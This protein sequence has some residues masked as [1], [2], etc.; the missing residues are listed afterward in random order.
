MRNTIALFCFLLIATVAMAQPINVATF[1]LRYA[2]T[3]DTGNLWTSRAPMVANLIR[4]HDLDIFGTQEALSNQLNDISTALPQ[5]EHYG[6]G[7]DDGLE[8]GEHSAV[9]YK[10]DKYRLLNKGSFW[11]S[12]TPEKPSLGWDAT[13]CNRICS[14]VYLQDVATKKK[15]YFFNVHYDHQGKVA[16]EESSKLILARIKTIAGTQPVILTGDFNG[17]HESVPYKLIATS[18]SLRDTYAQ[19][20]YPYTNNNPTY[21]DFGRSLKNDQIID[22]IFTSSQFKVSRW[23]ILTDSYRGKFPSDH[24]PVMATVSLK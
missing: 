13:C 10:K 4:F 2:N 24:F 16:R 20:K 5:Y 14:W 17:D 11:L 1:N 12:Q 8:K 23:G 6:P 9:F 7:R 19:V 22:H 21:Q 18:G 15:F 3:T